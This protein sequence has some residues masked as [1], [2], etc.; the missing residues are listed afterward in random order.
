VYEIDSLKKN[1]VGNYA[2][3]FLKT[4]ISGNL[5]YIILI[6]EAEKEKRKKLKE[7]FLEQNQDDS[8]AFVG[9]NLRKSDN[10]KEDSLFSIS[11]LILDI[12]G[13]GFSIVDF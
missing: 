10:K 11:S 13:I 1:V 3:L 8:M 6:N 9:N 4:K 12:E 5:R 2:K 7:K